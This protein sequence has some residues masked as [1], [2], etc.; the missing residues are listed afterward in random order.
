MAAGFSAA[1]IAQSLIFGS[2]DA[3]NERVGRRAPD[4]EDPEPPLEDALENDEKGRPM[5]MYVTL[6]EDMVVAIFHHE[7][8]LFHLKETEFVS[9]LNDLDYSAK[10]LLIRLCLRKHGWL[11]QSSL[12]YQSE[13]GSGISD[14]LK[15]L[16]GDQPAVEEVAIKE[17]ELEVID[18]T[19]DEVEEDARAQNKTPTSTPVQP[20]AGPS[21]IKMEEQAAAVE[22]CGDLSFF[23]ED[24]T[25][26][27]L[28]ELLECLT[29]EELKKLAKQMKVR[30]TG[31]RHVL[32][33]ALLKSSS[34]QTTLPFQPIKKG[35]KRKLVQTTLSFGQR[36]QS[37]RLREMVMEILGCCVRVNKDVV[38]LLRRLNLVYYRCTEHTT[39]ILTPSILNR[40]RKRNYANYIHTRTSHIWPSREALIAYEQALALEA[41]IDTL[42]DGSSSASARS[43]SRSVLSRTPAPRAELRSTSPIKRKGPEDKENVKD[44]PD[45]DQDE[46]IEESARVKDARAIK[47]IFEEVYPKWVAL[48]LTKGDEDGRQRGLERFDEGHVLT[49]IVRKGCEALGILKEYDR[50]LEVLEELIKQRRWHRGRRGQLYDRRA[51]ILMH[52]FPKDDDKAARAL[53]GVKEALNDRDTHLVSRPMLERRLTRLEKRLNIA[54]DLR[55]TCEG[56]LQPPQNVKISGDRVRQAALHLD[57]IGRKILPPAGTQSLEHF[58]DSKAQGNGHKPT[59]SVLELEQ[60]G[61]STWKGNDDE[62]VN[63]ETLALQH[64]ERLGYKGYHCE[65]SIVRTLFGILFWDI[66]FAPV[67]G[68][69]ETP[70]QAAPLDIMED[71]FYFAREELIEQR[72]K[73]LEEG[74]AGKILRSVDEEHRDKNTWCVGVDWDAFPREHLFEIIEC[75]PSGAALATICRLFCEE[76]GHRSSGLPD[77][78]IWNFETQHLK[79]VEVKG[80]G[81][82]LQENQK[83][84][85]DVLH[86]AGFDVEVCHVVDENAPQPKSTKKAGKRKAKV[87]KMKL[88]ESDSNTEVESEDEVDQLNE[89]QYLD[90]SMRVSEA[91][92]VSSQPSSS[93]THKRSAD[94]AEELLTLPSPKRLRRS[95]RTPVPSGRVDMDN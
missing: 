56:K 39:N 38:T 14:A 57:R 44:D 53:Q 60:K 13:L 83:L 25:H 22:A 77:L 32:H 54:H 15:V 70:Y 16:C 63:V 2:G 41:E 78:F 28:S 40:A 17:E 81:D 51:L 67:S 58:F 23:A 31:S 82:T 47:C 6:F 55:H 42:L 87:P 37:S 35:S 36:S 92:F 62:I 52:H 91:T 45:D 86:R 30:A 88:E 33:Q 73:E 50:E 94:E 43:R 93:Q 71:S 59:T 89:S 3:P 24:H 69:F 4:D 11:R 84:W 8:H 61:K 27:S 26:A 74:F 64:Y 29:V 68:A 1:Q 79:F 46:V 75:F 90:T 76:Y 7:A 20:E 12:K 19:F 18:L 34:T 72:L 65:G 48:V 5:S 49:R 85:I 9:K 10:Y 21:S 66:I 80:P 95:T